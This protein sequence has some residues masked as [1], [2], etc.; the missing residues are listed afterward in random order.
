MG[1][2]EVRGNATRTV[3]CDTMK[4]EICF[5]SEMNTPEAASKKAMDECEAFLSELKNIGVDISKITLIE[6][7][8]NKSASYSRNDE[9][10]IKYVADREIEIISAFDMTLLNTI[11]SIANE[12]KAHI[13]F[14]SRFLISNEAE[15]SQELLT[16]ALK[17]AKQRAEI[18]AQAIDQKVVDLVSADKN[19]PRANSDHSASVLCA[20]ASGD[21]NAVEYTSTNEIGPTSKTLSETIFTVWEVA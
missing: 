11:R 14:H 8:V 4:L 1:K 21:I 19:D 15:I 5:N 3:E 20:F 6:D 2:I 9:C 16:E 10:Q 18:M 13:S 12:A 17:D 7:S